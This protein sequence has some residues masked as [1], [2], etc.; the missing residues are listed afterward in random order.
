MQKN[1]GD[2]QVGSQQLKSGNDLGQLFYS[3]WVGVICV[4]EPETALQEGIHNHFRVQKISW[5]K[6]NAKG[7]ATDVQRKFKEMM[8]KCKLVRSMEMLGKP[9]T[10]NGGCF[11]CLVHMCFTG[12]LHVRGTNKRRKKICMRCGCIVAPTARWV[13]PLGSQPCTLPKRTEPSLQDQCR[14]LVQARRVA[15]AIKS[16]PGGTLLDEYFLATVYFWLP[17]GEFSSL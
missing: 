1:Q 12:S 17:T 9:S 5:M 8:M 11:I 4:E 7:S 13:G 6:W 15:G 3:V 16:V 10:G 2:S 14:A